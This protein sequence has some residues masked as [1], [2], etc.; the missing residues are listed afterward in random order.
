MAK[1]KYLHRVNKDGTWRYRFILGKQEFT[2]CTGE[3]DAREASRVATKIRKKLDVVDT[4]AQA[5]DQK[6]KH[7]IGEMKVLVAGA[8]DAFDEGFLDAGTSD[9]R[10]KTIS[11]QWNNFVEWM[12]HHHPKVDYFVS[13]KLLAHHI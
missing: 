12:A 5:L 9:D 6:R 7:L 13:L 4:I 2:G 3:S 10:R 8:W 11:G 1:H